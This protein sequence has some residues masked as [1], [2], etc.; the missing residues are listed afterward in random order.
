MESHSGWSRKSIP[1]GYEKPFHLATKSIFGAFICQF[2]SFLYFFV[3][4][5]S[6][7]IFFVNDV[8]VMEDDNNTILSEEVNMDL[9]I[10]VGVSLVEDPLMDIVENEVDC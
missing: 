10:C 6:L 5:F 2:M 9:D 3:I 4:D 8:G 1:V 7:C